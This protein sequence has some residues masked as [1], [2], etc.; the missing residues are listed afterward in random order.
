MISDWA[1]AEITDISSSQRWEAH[2][3]AGR[4]CPYSDNHLLTRSSHYFSILGIG[5]VYFRFLSCAKLW[6]CM[7]CSRAHC[8]PINLCCML[9]VKNKEYLSK[10]VV[11]EI[12]KS[13]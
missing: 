8:A 3:E 12:G 7:R 6:T 13:I 11:Y 1:A 10:D 4:C 2:N 5:S 9:K